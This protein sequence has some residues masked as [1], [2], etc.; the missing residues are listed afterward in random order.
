MEDKIEQLSKFIEVQ[1]TELRIQ[2]DMLS[3]V[4]GRNVVVKAKMY[5][6]EKIRS[7]IKINNRG[8]KIGE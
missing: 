3:D 5:I 1:L 2:D 7:I 4:T 6:L 8:D